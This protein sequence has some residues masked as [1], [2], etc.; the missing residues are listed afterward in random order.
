MFSPKFV[1]LFVSGITRKLLNRFLLLQN[2]VERWHMGYGRNIGGN[3]DH[4]TLGVRYGLWSP[5]GGLV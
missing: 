3:P 2:S 4:V 1:C 5:G